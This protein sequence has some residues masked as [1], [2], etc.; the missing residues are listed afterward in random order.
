MKSY[1]NLYDK[2]YSNENILLAFRKARKGKT[3]KSYIIKFEENL[4]ENLSILQKELKNQTYQPVPLKKDIIRDPKTRK[5]FKAIFRDRIVH[6]IIVNILEPI[7][8]PTFIHDSYASR[9]N[10]GHHKALKRFDYFKRKV[11]K[12]NTKNCYILK[13]DIKHYF[14]E[15][16]HDILLNIISKKIRDEKVIW[17]VKK[18]LESEEYSKINFKGMPLGN[19]TSQFLAN[20]YLNDFDHFVKNKLK[21]KYYIRYVDDFVIFNNS[22]EQLILWKNSINSFLKRKLNLELHPDKSKILE[23]KEGINFLGFKIFYYYRLLKKSNIKLMKRNIKEWIKLL[24]QDKI[25][26]EKIEQKI[27]GWIAHAKHGST[28]NLIKNIIFIKKVLKNGQCP[29]YH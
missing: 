28:S 20:V 18:I 11:S 24:E 26:E 16:N 17:L 7:F 19:H 27:N 9:K 23:L 3:R 8:E 2:L 25:S 5:I 6:H 15:I 14:E 21:C 29:A 4:I 1:N 13:A 22:K 10:K 12:N